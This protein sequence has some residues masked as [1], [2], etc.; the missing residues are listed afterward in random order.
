MKENI[1]P[2]D[3]EIKKRYQGLLARANDLFQKKKFGAARYHFNQALQMNPSP[4]IQKQILTCEENESRIARSQKLLKQGYQLQREKRIKEALEAFKLSLDAWDNKEI[5]KIVANLKSKLPRPN[6][7]L[8]YKFEAEGRYTEAIRYYRETLE[9]SGD[10]NLKD[11]LGICLVKQGEYPE[12]VK[13]LAD[14]PSHEPDVI[15]HKGYAL[16]RLGYYF[17]AIKQWEYLFKDF[18]EL[19][20]QKE[21]FLKIAVNDLLHRSKQEEGFDYAYQQLNN[22]L[23]D[24]PLPLFLDSIN[25]MELDHLER[26]WEKERFKEM[27]DLLIGIEKRNGKETGFLP[28]FLAKVYYRLAE[29]NVEYLPEAITFWLSVIYNPTNLFSLTDKNEK[30][31]TQLAQDLEQR[32]ER[33]I[34]DYQIKNEDLSFSIHWELERESVLFLYETAQKEPSLAKLICTPAFAERFNLSRLILDKLHRL[35][36]SWRED[37][38]FWVIGTLFSKARNSFILLKQ[39]KLN[40]ALAALPSRETGEFVDYCRQRISFQI[41]IENLR[42]KEATNLKK[43]FIQSIPLLQ[44]FELYIKGFI[45]EALKIKDEDDL[46]RLIILDDVLQTLIRSVKTK[47]LLEIASYIMSYKAYALL[48][49][50]AIGV[51]DVARICN[52]ALELYPDNEFAKH[53]LDEMGSEKAFDDVANAFKKGNIKKAANIVSSMN[54]ERAEELFFKYIDNTLDNFDNYSYNKEEKISFLDDLYE[55]CLKVDPDNSTIDD[56][57]D[58]LEELE[59]EEKIEDKKKRRK[60]LMM[61][62]ECR[63]INDEL[64]KMRK[65]RRRRGEDEPKSI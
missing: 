39:G 12:A 15:Y 37:E 23:K 47:G 22:L 55:G 1:T 50:E 10:R 2:E 41:G 62:D 18:S 21:N 24:Y 61:N 17:E 42:K 60:K 59:G 25:S 56:I 9:S 49:K 57:L 48:N 58:K 29:I 11:R 64:K 35:K 33:L 4:E 63:M 19:N 30:I 20:H 54:D 26:L 46:D 31:D 45:K 36:P 34:H 52:K 28:C 27:L 8:A 51:Q 5:S 44:R 3:R 7:T 14:S 16:A 53:G 43:Y 38:R 40:E 13:I 32:L 65:Q 6:L